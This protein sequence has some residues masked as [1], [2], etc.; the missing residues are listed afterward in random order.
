MK[1]GECVF[2]DKV[3]GCIGQIKCR[4]RVG[5]RPEHWQCGLI[6]AVR[7]GN[8]YGVDAMKSDD[9]I[10]RLVK[11]QT[12]A[13]FKKIVDVTWEQR[14]RVPCFSPVNEQPKA[15]PVPPKEYPKEEKSLNLE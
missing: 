2:G 15:G 1:C 12:S 8:R 10:S 9:H 3:H 6:E 11:E 5:V 7:N 14:G 4:E 13:V